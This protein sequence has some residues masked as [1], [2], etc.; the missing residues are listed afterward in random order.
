MTRDRTLLSQ[1]P[2]DIRAMPTPSPSPNRQPRGTWVLGL[3]RKQRAVTLHL[4]SSQPTKQT[5]GSQPRGKHISCSFNCLSTIA[6]I[7]MAA[8]CRAP[9]HGHGK[10]NAKH[11]NVA[12]PKCHV[13]DSNRACPDWRRDLD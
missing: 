6:Q 10:I 7:V 5:L 2:I 4:I 11:I 13:V 12:D 3:H 8:R 9:I 1:R